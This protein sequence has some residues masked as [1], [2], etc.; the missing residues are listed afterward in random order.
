[1]PPETGWTSRPTTAVDAAEL[2]TLFNRVYG[3]E[4]SRA[5]PR[6]ERHWNWK[7]F[8]NPRGNH[9]LL[10]RDTGSGQVLAHA[11][12]LPCSLSV[13]GETRLGV[14]TVDHMVDDARRRGLRR[15]GLFTRLMREWVDT[16]CGPDGNAVGWGFPSQANLRIGRRHLGYRLVRPLNALVCRRLDAWAGPHAGVGVRGVPRFDADADALWSRCARELGVVVERRAAALNWRYAE[17]PDVGYHLLE[18]RDATDGA[19]RGLAVL[20]F[21]GLA[22]DV[23]SIMD[24]LVPGDDLDTT[25][26]LLEACAHRASRQGYGTL[27]AWFPENMGW[28]E[29]FQELGFAVRFTPL[30]LVARCFDG[31]LD[32]PDLRARCSMTLGDIDFL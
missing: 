25:R 9:S 5:V 20:R 29:R 10:A 3:R 2:N 27:A 12:G 15:V 31:S 19:L 24:W 13:E 32:I 1:M 11:G 28:F 7:Y 26:A 8:A 16:Y 30:V 17:H 14:Q 18:A 21:G 6:H 4:R 23:A 22:D